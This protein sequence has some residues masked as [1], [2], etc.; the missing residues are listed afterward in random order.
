MC[1]PPARSGTD[2]PLPVVRH[3]PLTAVHVPPDTIAVAPIV[4][5]RTSFALKPCAVKSALSVV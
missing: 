3:P 1:R 5:V 4:I 2:P